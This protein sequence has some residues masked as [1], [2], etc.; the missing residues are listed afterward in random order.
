MRLHPTALDVLSALPNQ[1]LAGQIPQVH[2]SVVSDKR[3]KKR[4]KDPN[5]PKRPMSAY[6]L[7]CQGRRETLKVDHPE[8][9]G[10]AALT[11]RVGEEWTS[12]DPKMKAKYQAEAAIALEV[13]KAQKDAYDTAQAALPEHLRFS[14]AAPPS[15]EAAG[16][17]KRKR[18]PNAPKKPI[19]AYLLFCQVE[20]AA[21]KLKHPGIKGS[22]LTKKVGEAWTTLSDEAKSK[23]HDALKE[24]MATYTAEKAAYDRAQAALPE[25]MRFGFDAQSKSHGDG[26]KKRITD[27]NAP[28]KPISA[29]LLFCEEERK[30]LKAQHKGIK[31]SE[32]TKKVGE[33]WT[34]LG[35]KAKAKFHDAFA[36]ALEMYKLNKAAYDAG[37]GFPQ[38]LSASLLPP[39]Q[40]AVYSVQI[41]KD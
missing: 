23:F 24:A 3:K 29:Y 36:K 1:P 41:R 40:G 9:K 16:K 5:A 25:N 4:K 31:G 14:H 35:D 26:K 27:P 8:I 18:D 37:T 21:I 7:F 10:P 17:K 2:P 32:L 38:P 39:K 28:K 15:P 11:R 30:K 22:E 13:W 12:M 20:R 34:S 6:L 19:S 33:A